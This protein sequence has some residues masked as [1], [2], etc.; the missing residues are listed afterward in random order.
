MI[1]YIVVHNNIHR[2]KIVGNYQKLYRKIKNNPK[3]VKFN[4]LEKLMT[5][6]GGF[7]SLPGKGDHY[8]FVHPD[9]DYPIVVDTRGKRKPL[10]QYIVKKCLRVFEELNPHF[11]KED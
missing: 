1:S 9:L 6:V 2:G 3:D 7:T 10:K 4:D 11:G 8:S 5:K